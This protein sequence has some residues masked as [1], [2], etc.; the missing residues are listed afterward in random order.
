MIQGFKPNIERIES[1]ADL[2]FHSFK[3]SYYTRS[4]LGDIRRSFLLDT[5]VL[6][7]IKKYPHLCIVSKDKD[8][9][10]GAALFSNTYTE[11]SEIDA[12]PGCNGF[13]ILLYI[14]V[15]EQAR[16]QGIGS[17]LITEVENHL[18]HNGVDGMRVTCEST[19]KAANVLYKKNGY[20]LKKQ[21]VLHQGEASVLRQANGKSSIS[22]NQG[23]KDGLLYHTCEKRGESTV[24]VIKPSLKASY[25]DITS[26][27][28]GK[29]YDIAEVY[30]PVGESGMREQLTG[31]GCKEIL[32]NNVYIKKWG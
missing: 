17:A 14:C 6:P 8:N 25:E 10:N 20:Q 12:I 15:D 11:V 7:V 16:K 21:T 4:L 19:N 5:L 18:K 27:L 24:M 28:A 26:L 32:I 9:I 23:K 13:G 22:K 3:D 31:I 30:V 2:F 1:I 29:A